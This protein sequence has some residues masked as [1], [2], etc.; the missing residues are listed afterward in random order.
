MNDPHLNQARY[1]IN[2]S[3]EP[4][5]PDPTIEIMLA[6]H[7]ILKYLEPDDDSK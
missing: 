2:R 1:H 4:H 6:V 5:C 3:K 7:M